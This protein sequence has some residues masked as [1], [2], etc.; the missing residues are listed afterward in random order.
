[1]KMIHI[2]ATSQFMSIDEVVPENKAEQRLKDIRDLWEN[3]E[4]HRQPL[5]DKLTVTT[6]PVIL[7]SSI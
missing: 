5:D 1:M 3:T 6:Q 4:S 7:N 2:I